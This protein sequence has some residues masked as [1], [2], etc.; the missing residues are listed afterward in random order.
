MGESVQE[1]E[2]KSMNMLQFNLQKPKE[3]QILR[4]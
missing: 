1:K 2:G 3:A 4:I